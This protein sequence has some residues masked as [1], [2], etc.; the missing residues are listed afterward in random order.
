MDLTTSKAIAD[1]QSTTDRIADL[2]R[3]DL[4]LP[5]K[6]I[7]KAASSI[8]IEIYKP[9]VSKQ[10]ERIAELLTEKWK[11]QNKLAIAKIIKVDLSAKLKNTFKT[12][13]QLSNSEIGKV[14]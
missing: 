3:K 10:T 14:G 8:Y 11:L 4:A 1:R 7:R 2:L 9:A 6:E 13:L 12:L 5:E